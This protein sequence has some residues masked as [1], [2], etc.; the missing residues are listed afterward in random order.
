M[1]RDCGVCLDSLPWVLCYCLDGEATIQIVGMG[2]VLNKRERRRRLLGW[3]DTSRRAMPW[4]ALPGAAPDPYRVWLSEIMLQQ[5]TVATVA[6]YFNNFIR[7]W[8]DVVSLA[9]AELD[10][11]LHGWQGLGYYARARNL[12]RCARVVADKLGGR[13]PADETQLL[14]LPGIGP[15]TAAAIAAIAFD[16]PANVV[17]GNVERVMARLFAVGTPLPGAKAELRELG[18][19]LTGTERPGDYAQALMDLGAT[20]CTPTGPRCPVCPWQAGCAARR[21][22]ITGELPR[23]ERKKPRPLRRGIVFWAVNR[24]GAVLLRRR[25]EKG[26]L[27]GMMEF[28]S[29]EWR[30]GELDK[31]AAPDLAPMSGDWKE[32]PGLVRYVF[33]HFA[34]ELTVMAAEVHSGEIDGAVWCPVERLGEYALPSMMKKVAAHALGAPGKE[35]AA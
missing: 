25:P 31:A 13:F 16:I 27:G 17:D 9:A 15:Y 10:D 3:Y 1:G 2:A 6:P 14:A 18:A 33:T 28:P 32:R 11:V 20:V 21:S 7:R 19:S 12:H 29:T 34:L 22:G 8:P 35:L 26:L 5:T 4:R 24:D 23:R 30:E